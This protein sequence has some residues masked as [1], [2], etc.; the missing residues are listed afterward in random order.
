[1]AQQKLPAWFAGKADITGGTEVIR[2]TDDPGLIEAEADIAPGSWKLFPDTAAGKAAAE[3]YAGVKSSGIQPGNPV[4]G[5][6]TAAAGTV[7][8]S[9]LSFA[10]N[11]TARSLWLRIV[12]VTI[13]MALILTGIN[14][15]TGAA[16]VLDKLPK[17]IPV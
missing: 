12:K 9:F 13:G 7:G 3:K 6:V 11:L 8:G 1:M 16:S 2:V 14:R 4:T 5:A 15:L 10:D 17:V